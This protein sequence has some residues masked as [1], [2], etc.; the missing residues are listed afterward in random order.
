MS[1]SSD[2]AAAPTTVA[3]MASLTQLFEENYDRL[4]GL[5]NWRMD[6]RLKVRI[7]AE[8]VLQQ[9]FL[10]AMTRWPTFAASGISAFDWL[11][12]IAR[13]CL[14][15]ACRRH[16]RTR[17]NYITERPWP[18]GSS[19][20]MAEGLVGSSTSPSEAV[21]RRELKNR[22]QQALE[23]LSWTDREIIWMRD[24]KG[25]SNQNVAAAL[26]INADTAAQRYCRAMLRLK[27]LLEDL[28]G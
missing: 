12:R 8:D 21:A 4:L 6:P 24:F 18:D 14:V 5:V 11:Y 23:R 7:S 1:E 22:V 9:A 10:M 15:E 3:D 19:E 13:D 25:L 28:L 16:L 17:R 20:Q 26:A 2:S 27:P